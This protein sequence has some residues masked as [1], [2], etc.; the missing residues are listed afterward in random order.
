VSAALLSLRFCY[1]EPQLS[2]ALLSV[3]HHHPKRAASDETAPFFMRLFRLPLIPFG[4]LE[5][6]SAPIG[7]IIGISAASLVAIA[8]VVAIVLIKKKKT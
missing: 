8:A 2:G 1:D 7:L 3:E 4:E 5:K 6:D